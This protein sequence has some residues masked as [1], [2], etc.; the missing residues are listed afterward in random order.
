MELGDARRVRA[1]RWLAFATA[2]L[3]ACSLGWWAG[4]ST[5]V[6]SA[7]TEPTAQPLTVA[8][9][10]GTVGKSL[11]FNVT[12]SQ[13]LRLVAANL[14]SGVV[15]SAP[16]GVTAAPGDALYAVAGVTVRAVEG[17][18]PFYRD[19]V[20][21]VK[22][23]D[24]AELQS[25][26]AHLGFLTGAVDGRFGH[27]TTRAVKA[28]QRSTGS[29]QTGVV[30]LGEL[31]AI[32]TLPS[33]VT[34]DESIHLGAVLVGSEPAVR[35]PGDEPAFA[36]VVTSDQA[37]LIPPGARVDVRSGDTV[38][39]AVVGGATTDGTSDTVSLALRAPDGT[40][41]CGD[42]CL[43]LPA[44]ETAYLLGQV[45]VVPEASGPII[46]A[47]AI[48][49]RATGETYVVRQDGSEQPVTVAASA[50]GVVVVDGLH[51]GDVVLVFGDVQ[52][53]EEGEATDG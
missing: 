30:R 8:V 11:T 26:L 22:G 52:P 21:G 40:S 42:D 13:P 29:E 48:R 10:E 35:V 16:S 9:T 41:V 44:Q 27:D 36:L 7:P 46:P 20:A 25:A 34:L 47:A 4:R 28:W 6:D 19:L 33:T 43:A 2:I 39:N 23:E 14:L 15:T 12:V 45:H 24:V 18:V 17:D 50:D 31:V 1:V 37:R 5:V 3:T 53:S 38:W 32:P 51:T 49:T